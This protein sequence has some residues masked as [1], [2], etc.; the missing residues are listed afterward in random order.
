MKKTNDEDE[1]EAFRERSSPFYLF[2]VLSLG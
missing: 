1:E 2:R